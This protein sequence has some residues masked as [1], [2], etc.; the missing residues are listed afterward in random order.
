MHEHCTL[1]P[2]KPTA[3][4]AE[5]GQ[6]SRPHRYSLRNVSR[7]GLWSRIYNYMR[8]RYTIR[9]SS[10]TPARAA[11]HDSC[12]LYTSC[13]VRLRPVFTGLRGWRGGE[14]GAPGVCLKAGG[15]EAPPAALFPG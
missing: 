1:K 14:G 8:V 10:P 4:S 5:G 12:A 3:I 2:L 7:A 6:S 11:K 9:C 13:D 15:N